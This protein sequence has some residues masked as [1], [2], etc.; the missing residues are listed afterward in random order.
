MHSSGSLLKTFL[1]RIR[2]ILDEPDLD[3]KYDDA[4]VVKYVAGPALVDILS[5]LSNTYSCPVVL[6]HAFTLD[7]TISRYVLPPAIL[8]VLNLRFVDDEGN[9]LADLAPRSPWHRLGQGWSLEGNPGSLVLRFQNFP[10]DDQLAELWYTPSGDVQSHY[11]TGILA[12]VDGTARVELATTPT[13]GLLDRRE[14]AYAGQQLRIITT[15]PLP[16]GVRNITRSYYES[17]KWYAE[18]DDDFPDDIV[19]GSVTYEVVPSGDTAFWEAV[20]YWG[21][22]KLGGRSLSEAY[23]EHLKVEYR[24]AIKTVGDAMTNVQGRLPKY[25]EKDTMDNRD[26]EMLWFNKL[27]FTQ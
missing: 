13:L 5:R 17:S 2:A 19:D 14:N 3:A 10:P 6:R 21:A 24:S 7:S 1:E 25:I 9:M 12:R 27:P 22:L 16:I 8:Q 15:S 26:D 11:G 23:R 20:A 4:Y 18:V